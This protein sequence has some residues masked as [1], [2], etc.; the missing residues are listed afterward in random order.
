VLARVTPAAL[1][2]LLNST[3]AGA[4]GTHDT[5]KPAAAAAGK[6]SAANAAS[7]LTAKAPPGAQAQD[8]G[9]VLPA[10]AAELAAGYQVPSDEALAASNIFST[11]EACLLAWMSHHMAKAFPHMVR[12]CLAL[13]V[14]PALVFMWHVSCVS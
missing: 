14:H 3:Q 2:Q 4:H 8:G 1:R 12:R 9:D 13:T 5:A 10:T 11:A 6:S 7:T